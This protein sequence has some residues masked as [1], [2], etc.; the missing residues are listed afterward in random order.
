[1]TGSLQK[2]T[3][4]SGNTYF[5]IVLNTKPS[6]KWIPTGLQVK[7]N[8]RAAIEMLNK[9]LAE[10][11][12][13]EE[14]ACGR[15]TACSCEL[16]LEKTNM[17]EDIMFSDWIKKWLE[18]RSV[19]VRN[20]TIESYEVH[21][22]RIISYFEEKKTK[23]VEITYADIE[24]YCNY[25]MKE[26]KVDKRTGEKSG[27][28]IRTVRSQKFIISS[29]LDWAVLHKKIPNNPALNV[30]VSSKK[31]RQLARK[32]VF[33]NAKEANMFLD[34][35]KENDDVLYDI[36]FATLMYGLR[37]SEALGLTVQAVDFKEKRLYI[38]RTVVKMLH[39]HDEDDTKTYDS[40][41]EY[42]LTD[43]MIG[44][45]KA[46]LAKKKENRFYYGNKYVDTDFLF[47]WEDG[48]PFS[49]DYIS[50]HHKKMV[51]KFGKPHLTFHNLRHSTACIL[52]ERGWGAKEI[53][54]WLGHADYYTT[55]NIYTHIDKAHRRKQA[56]SL[57]GVLEHSS[58]NLRAQQLN[59]RNII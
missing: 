51:N 24:D 31:N 1:M 37:R 19:D 16:K 59:V 44:F 5:Y 40:D 56:D 14:N 53:Q 50:K 17:D 6:P 32:P 20:C 42:P 23:L 39:I 27:Y 55:M 30:K 25:M 41:R 12:Q 18:N 33:F 34:F 28:A 46:V 9:T 49:P 21:S 7:G 26:G 22:R 58:T 15:V 57:N 54:E 11:S 10:Y 36:T 52:Y 47:T 48:H 45:F 3:M 29:A 8:K 35:L 43:E 2:K 13:N 38:N 4:K